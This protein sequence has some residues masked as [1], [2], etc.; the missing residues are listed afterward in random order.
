MLFL[1]IVESIERISATGH[2]LDLDG[3]SVSVELDNEID[4]AAS[5][6]NIRGFDDGSPGLEETTGDVFAEPA[7]RT[8]RQI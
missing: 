1:G 7:D 5:D 2:G 4:L 3:D 8:V 6:S